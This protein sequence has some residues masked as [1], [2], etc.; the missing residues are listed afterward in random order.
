V[1]RDRRRPGKFVRRHFEVCVF[2]HLADELRTGDVA[3]IGS[4]SYANWQ[5]QLLP[6]EE[7]EPMVAGYCA[8]AGLPSSPSEFTAG[9]QMRLAELAASVEA[10]YPDNA[11][12]VI[13]EEG[14]AVLKAREGKERRASAL[15]LEAAIKD[16]L[17]ERPL[18]DIL[19]RVSRGT[20]W[21]RHFGPLS[22]SEPKLADPLAR[23]IPVA[24]TYGSRR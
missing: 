18:L 21:H 12:L 6:W 10:G 11:D 24:F 19:A 4:A 2:S 22:V 9:L 17:P 20:D 3:V 15:A 14:G 8:E 5:T 16:R 1:I 13:D 23:Y 7:C